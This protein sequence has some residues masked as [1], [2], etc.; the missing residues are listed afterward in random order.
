MADSFDITYDQ[1]KPI[2]DELNDLRTFVWL[3]AEAAYGER[4]AT[5]PAGT[6]YSHRMFGEDVSALLVEGFGV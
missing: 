5:G 3:V 1:L 6:D 4:T 2:L